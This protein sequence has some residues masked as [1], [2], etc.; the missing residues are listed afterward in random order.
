MR[1]NRIDKLE[2]YILE[3]RSASL[4]QLCAEF[5]I[6]KPTLRRDLDALMPRHTIEKVYGGVVA[7]A[8]KTALTE[9][10]TPFAERNIKNAEA[11]ARVARLAAGVVEDNDTIFI[12]SGT[13]TLGIA[14]NLAGV[15]NLT[16]ITN[17]LLVASR[18]LAN[19]DVRTIMLP[20][21]VNTRTASTV[22]NECQKMLRRYHIKKA[23]MACSGV[24]EHGVFN[25]LPEEY[26]VK[27]TALEQSKLH[28]LLVDSSKFDRAALMAYSSLDQFHWVFADAQPQE[29][30]AELLRQ[31]HVQ[32]KIAAD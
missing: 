12:D 22:G 13:S 24:T 17:S 19:D 11:K 31:N 10:L 1:A 16:V 6:S 3:Q 25:N 2:A 20:G 21:I 23:F 18:L 5:G 8:P 7:V 30:Y 4:D 14:D 28:C 15:R 26:E 29:K 9:S 32:V 27:R